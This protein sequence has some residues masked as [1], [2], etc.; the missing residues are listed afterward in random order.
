M[1]QISLSFILIGAIS[2]NQRPIFREGLLQNAANF[3]SFIE[4][5][6]R[7]LALGKADDSVGGRAAGWRSQGKRIMSIT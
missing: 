5:G 3:H 4:P 6:H 1:T 2:V 7:G